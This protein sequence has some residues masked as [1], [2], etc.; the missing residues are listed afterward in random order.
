M[1]SWRHKFHLHLVSF[2]D[3]GFFI[4]R[5]YIAEDVF[6][7]DNAGSLQTQ[8]H[9]S[10]RSYHFGVLAALCCFNHD[11]IT[12]DL[13]DDR[14]VLVA[15]QRLLVELA[16]LTGNNCVPNIVDFGVDIAQL[17]ATKCSRRIL[18]E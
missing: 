9:C 18:F 3:H 13:N 6:L 12:V 17:S 16:C 7:W 2:T 4:L 15:V 5:H 8:H 11:V 10:V 1:T 14:D